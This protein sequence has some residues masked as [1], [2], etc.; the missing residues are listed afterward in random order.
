MTRNLMKSADDA[1]LKA[2]GPAEP[3]IKQRRHDITLRDGYKTTAWILQPGTEIDVTTARPL[4]VLFHGG[5]FTIGTENHMI[6]YGR[7]LVRLFN[8]VVVSATYRLAP[9]YPHPYGPID[10]WDALQWAAANARSLSADP[11]L[12]F[13]V[14][15]VSAGGN[16]ATVLSQQAKD[17]NLGPPLTGSWICVPLL[18]PPAEHLPMW[19]S[20]EQN[21][22]APILSTK[23]QSLL[24]GYYAADTSSP[25][26]SPFNS[27]DAHTGLPPA[28]L[29]VCGGDPL[30]D[31]GLILYRALR[32]VDVKTRLDVYPGMPHGFWTAFPQFETS[33]L[34][35]EDLAEGF[36]WLLGTKVDIDTALS[37]FDV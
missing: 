25:W 7:G 1:K 19:F 8:A 12:G 2:L 17:R 22:K 36:A 13:I 34:F 37:L 14:G 30:R 18:V 32:E 28:Y 24:D 31:D 4:I 21:A 11:H 5:G 3:E 20:R 15:G 26:Y 6:R 16:L 27:K 29:Q 10:A 35:I 9:E 33:K 23:D